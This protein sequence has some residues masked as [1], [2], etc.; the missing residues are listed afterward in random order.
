MSDS[1][2]TRDDLPFLVEAM[3]RRHMRRELLAADQPASADFGKDDQVPP[4][5]MSIPDPVTVNQNGTMTEA[6][7][8]ACSM[9]MAVCQNMVQKT[10]TD[11]ATAAGIAPDVAL[12]SMNAWLK[13]Y[14][15]FPFPFFTFK[16][17]Q[18]NTY[19]KDEFS[20]NADPDVVES[21][22]NIKNVAGLKD[23]VV[24]ALRKSGGNL[25]SYEGTEQ[26]FNYF[27]VI[28][29]YNETEIS[30]RVIKYAMNLKKTVVKTL[31]GGFEKTALDSAYD[32]YQ[33]VAD[34]ELMIKMQ[35]KMG[36]QM[37]DYMADKLLQ[38]VKAFYDQQLQRFVESIGVILKGES[39]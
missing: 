15:E 26:H 36:D 5:S 2:F 28:T 34:K 17:T 12:K 1:G 19:K 4:G 14:V 31:C 37:V 24:G 25:A 30:V 38:F 22:V 16:D 23:A 3:D 8:K 6:D 13:A 20:L 27:G 32:T 21:I 39:K 11:A 35:A 9:V 7:Y 18:S 10:L 29:A 33:F